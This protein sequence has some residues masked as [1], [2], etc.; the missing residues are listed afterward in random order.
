M[1]VLVTNPAIEIS[2]VAAIFSEKVAVKVTTPEVI[3]LSESF[4]ES[5]SV[6]FEVGEG[7]V[8]KTAIKLLSDL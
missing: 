6:A 4:D 7:Q 3:M 2:G 1:A 8:P 5:V